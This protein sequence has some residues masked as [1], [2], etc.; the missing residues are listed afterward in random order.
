MVG[1]YSLFRGKIA[2]H[3]CLLKVIA[4]HEPYLTCVAVDLELLFQHPAKAS[5]I[6]FLQQVTEGTIRDFQQLGRPR[7]NAS[8]LFQSRFDERALNAGD[9][10]IKIQPFRGHTMLASAIS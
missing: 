9:I 6:V 2:I 3:L 1:W 8:G 10:A 5:N 7:L 4:T